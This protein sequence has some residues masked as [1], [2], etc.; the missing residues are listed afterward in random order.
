[1]N[2]I[3][4]IAV[5]AIIVVA[6]NQNNKPYGT[7]TGTLKNIKNDTTFYLVD[8][9]TD[10]VIQKFK[11][12]KGHFKIR[13][14][15]SSPKQFLIRP[16]IYKYDKDVFLLWLDNSPTKLYGNMYNM[17]DSKIEGSIPNKIY[18]QYKII[19]KTH[20]A[21]FSRINLSKIMTNDQKVR[22]SLSREL[23]NL[24]NDYKIKL[25]QFFSNNINSTV[26]F[27][28]LVYEIVR[29]NSVLT[30]ADFKQLYTNLP[31]EF[32]V[33]RDGILLKNFFSMTD[34]PKIGEKFIDFSQPTPEGKVESVSSHLGK[35]TILE[36]WS[37]SCGNCRM[38]HPRLRKLYEKYHNAGFNIIGISLDNNLSDWVGAIK[39]DSIPWLNISDLKGYYNNGALLYGAKLIP[40]LILLDNKGIILDNNFRSKYM[41]GELE[42]LF[43]Y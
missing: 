33:S 42:K 34:V 7:L 22:D 2:K 23:S 1:M 14:S 37:S 3:L 26:A 28:Y 18:D 38:E 40:C 30:K 43:K 16:E 21:S 13:Y 29:Y 32:K 20:D 15:V 41:E 11:I 8:Y 31:E 10:T 24:Q 27:Y 5:V 36:F 12:T 9:E 19:E 39:K 25:M 4:F 6:C 35:Y 17:A